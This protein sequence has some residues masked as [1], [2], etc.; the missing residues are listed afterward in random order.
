MGR[1]KRT[2][3]AAM[4][5][6][7]A[8]TGAAYADESPRVIYDPSV[9]GNY[10]TGE[11]GGGGTGFI[12][13]AGLQ[14]I[15]D[16]QKR[17]TEANSMDA[18]MDMDIN[19]S[20][21]MTDPATGQSESLDMSMAMDM[22]MK[23][24]NISDPENMEYI[25]DVEMTMPGITEEKLDMVSFYKDGWLY[26]DSMGVKTKQYLDPALYGSGQMTDSMQQILDASTYDTS[27]F[28]SLTVKLH[29]EDNAEKNTVLAYTMDGQEIMDYVNQIYALMGINMS[30]MG[31][32]MNISD[33]T[34]EI[35]VN[36]A[37]YTT[38]DTM[39]MTLSMSGKEYGLDNLAL[40]MTAA[41]T[42]NAPG[43]P[44]DFVLPSTEGYTELIG[45]AEGATGINLPVQ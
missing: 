23:M 32:T 22:A 20:I 38:N 9:T 28:K 5:L 12:D 39:N 27:Y 29:E 21:A 13:E 30:D 34:G 2:F 6:T 35:T 15:T 7:F 3:I 14:L 31:F 43:A 45:G 19:M 17:Q 37:G 40:N 36:S 11:Q 42:Y 8:M 10:D 18:D 1:L 41:V 24:K 16:A 44:V 33:I 25:I 26:S 4:A